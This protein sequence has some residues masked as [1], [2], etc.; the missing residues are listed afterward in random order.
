MEKKIL[1]KDYSSLSIQK[2]HPGFLQESCNSE[3]SKHSLHINEKKK[4]CNHYF[5]CSLDDSCPCTD[6]SFLT[7]Q[8]S[9]RMRI[10]YKEICKEIV[11]SSEGFL[12]WF[13]SFLS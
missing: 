5:T 1:F 2:S 8:A 12:L 4:N 13:N 10:L 7:I 9:S 11:I 3:I 6:W